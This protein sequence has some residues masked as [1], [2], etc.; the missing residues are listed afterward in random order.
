[1]CDFCNMKIEDAL[2]VSQYSFITVCPFCNSIC[3]VAKEHNQEKIWH[4]RTTISSELTSFFERAMKSFDMTPEPFF[5]TGACKRPDY[6]H[7]I[8]HLRLLGD[9]ADFLERLK[10]EEKICR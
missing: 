10:K 9:P 1:M 8:I 2:Y 5:I 7:F 6:N 3:A 4:E